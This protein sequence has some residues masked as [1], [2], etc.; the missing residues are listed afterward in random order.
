G[1][2]I[3]QRLSR[4]GTV[5][6][7]PSLAQYG[8]TAAELLEVPDI[9]HRVASPFWTFMT[10][11]APIYEHGNVVTAP[12]FENPYYATGFPITEAYWANV[13]VDKVYRDVLIQCFERR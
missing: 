9:R 12:L 10:S 11:S 3:T 13:K 5:T 6:D 4:D 2:T 7:D 1:A 8:V